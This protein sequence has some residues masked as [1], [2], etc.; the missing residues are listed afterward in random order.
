[1]AKIIKKQ[2]IKIN[3]EGVIRIIKKN[4]GLLAGY[5]SYYFLEGKEIKVEASFDLVD[6]GNALRRAEGLIIDENELDEAIS[7]IFRE[8]ESQ[9]PH[10]KNMRIERSASSLNKSLN[11]SFDIDIAVAPVMP[12]DPMD[13]PGPDNP[14]DPD[15]TGVKR[16]EIM[17]LVR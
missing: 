14:M 6:I 16:A 2:E 12:V 15:P 1:M 5:L 8:I 11:V 7:K 4:W 13:I 3:L 17:Q 10:F 9:N